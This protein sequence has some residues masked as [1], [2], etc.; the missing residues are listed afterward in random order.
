MSNL[1]PAI[2]LMGPTASG[3]TALSLSIAQKFPVEIISVDSALI[4]RGMDIGTSKPGKS[5]LSDVPH[6]LID[7]CDPAESYSVAQFRDDALDAM[8]D[9]TERGKIPLLVGGTMLYY[10]GLTQGL[11]ELPAA[12]MKIRA[13]LEKSV[14][15][16]GLQ[17]LHERLKA[18]DPVAAQKIHPND[19]QRIQRALE[20]FEISGKPISVWWEEQKQNQLP[21]EIIKIAVSTSVRSLLHKRIENRFVEMLEQGV[22]EEVKALRSRGDLDLNK[23][24]M[25]AVGYR[26][27][28][29]YLNDE[30][31]FED[32]KQKSIAATRQLAKRQLTWLRSEQELH[33]FDSDKKNFHEPVLKLLQSI[34]S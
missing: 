1:P 24:S 9:I 17:V 6:H 13:D 8:R 7:I 23:P 32:M 22:V 10:R 2:L 33:W 15:E 4:Y 16:H 11:S 25:R 27:I 12:D 29:Q 3:K 20:V 30:F 26:Q 34:P 5:I 19:P 28:W 18:V 21:F 31:P 14:V